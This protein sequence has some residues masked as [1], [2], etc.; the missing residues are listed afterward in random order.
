M[1]F[2]SH[3]LTAATVTVVA[4]STGAAPALATSAIP[5]SATSQ[6]K[7][8]RAIE[9][10]TPRIRQNI[11]LRTTAQQRTAVSKLAAN[12]TR[13]QRALASVTRTPAAAA[14]RSGKRE[15]LIGVHAQV[16]A[17]QQ[18]AAGLLEELSGQKPTG[19]HELSLG[20]RANN[21]ADGEIARADS[22]LG[23]K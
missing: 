6:T 15:W 21:R 19:T 18:I 13:C 7:L 17:D 22:A 9:K 16:I 11:D 20:L 5:T 12:A 3:Q 8:V 2:K 10:S 14:Q 23:I 1:R 4:L